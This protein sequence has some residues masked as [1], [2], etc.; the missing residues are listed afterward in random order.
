MELVNHPF[1]VLSSIYGFDRGSRLWLSLA[2]WI[3]ELIDE[4]SC[5]RKTQAADFLNFFFFLGPTDVRNV[6]F[7]YKWHPQL[8]M[9]FLMPRLCCIYR[10]K[11]IKNDNN[12][13]HWDTLQ[14]CQILN[15]SFVTKYLHIT[16]YTLSLIWLSY[17]ISPPPFPHTHSHPFFLTHTHSL[18]LPSPPPPP[19][20]RPQAHRQESQGWADHYGGAW[21]QTNSP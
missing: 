14:Q 4:E 13:Y 16:T 10:Y 5:A 21:T 11:K 20:K 15:Q 18:T 17:I 3:I 19:P 12:I 8:E 7:L 6:E 9:R 1:H 2:P